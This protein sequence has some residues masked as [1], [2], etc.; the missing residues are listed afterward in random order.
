[1]KLLILALCLFLAGCNEPFKVELSNSEIPPKPKNYK[2]L[3]LFP[4][5]QRNLIIAIVNCGGDYDMAVNS[6]NDY[7]SK[8]KNPNIEEYFNYLKN[9]QQ[10]EYLAG[11]S[12]P[13]DKQVNKKLDEIRREYQL[14]QKMS[15]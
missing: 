8:T 13:T 4:E 3:L 12:V 5:F 7:N 14:I 6:I 11:Y 15:Q 2:R 1:M 10:S 9:I